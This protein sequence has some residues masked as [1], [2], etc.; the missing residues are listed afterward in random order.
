MTSEACDR[1]TITTAQVYRIDFPLP[2]SGNTHLPSGLS[3]ATS[4]QLQT[5]EVT[6]LSTIY[7]DIRSPS[8]RKM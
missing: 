7:T 1:Q 6:I 5:N 2:S 3:L 4:R 8:E